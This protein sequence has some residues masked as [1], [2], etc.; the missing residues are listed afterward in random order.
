M[1]KGAVF[2]DD[3]TRRLRL[4]RAWDNRKPFLIVI[5]T[6][7]SIADAETNDP[8][9]ERC[10]RR[11]MKLGY[12]AIVLNNMMDVIETD[13]KKLDHMSAEQ[14]C[15]NDNYEQLKAAIFEASVG[16]ADIL[17]AWGK[18]GQKYGAVAWFATQAAKSGV[19]LFCLKKNADGSPVH[20]LYQ[21][22]SKQFEWFAGT[23][24][25]DAAQ[26]LCQPVQ[27]ELL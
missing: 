20:P 16:N 21:P 10:Q 17:C 13:S 18:P 22:Y 24:F 23:D 15:S 6:N 1:D 2:N 27:K 7:P 12:G 4:W 5:G 14:R 8:T 26:P 11:A 19:T 25:K 9:V 3:K